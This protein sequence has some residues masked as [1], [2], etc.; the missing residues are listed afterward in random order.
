MTRQPRRLSWDEPAP[1]DLF[2][3]WL[4]DEDDTPEILP[5]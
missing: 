4:K 5:A 1:A 3:E 2:D